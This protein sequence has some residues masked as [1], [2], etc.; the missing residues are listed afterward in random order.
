MSRRLILILVGLFFCHFVFAQGELIKPVVVWKKAAA[1]SGIT[2]TLSDSATVAFDNTKPN[3]FTSTVASTANEYS[4]VG[5][6]ANAATIDSVL[7]DQAN[8]K[9][10]VRLDSIIGYTQFSLERVKLYGTKAVTAG[11]RTFSIYSQTANKYISYG[12]SH[13]YGV[14]QTTPTGATVGDHDVNTLSITNTGS[15]WVVFLCQAADAN[16]VY[17]VTTGTKA[18]QETKASQADGAMAYR[19]TTGTSVTFGTPPTCTY[20]VAF[21]LNAQ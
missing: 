17:Q 5:V 16:V 20:M 18:W 19:S 2:Y 14:S 21:V 6:I 3:T 1:A 13:F 8:G 15:N 10:N 4:V 11:T 9:T 7:V 12:V